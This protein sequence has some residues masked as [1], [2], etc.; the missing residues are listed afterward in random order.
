[1][2][3]WLVGVQLS[4]KELLLRGSR[5]DCELRE[6]TL[7]QLI[8]RSSSAEPSP[9]SVGVGATGTGVCRKAELKSLS[10]GSKPSEVVDG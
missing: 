10:G 2:S 4:V 7:D 8:P 1:M 3:S 9:A 6:S 5:S